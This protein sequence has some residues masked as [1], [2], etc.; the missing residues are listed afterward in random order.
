MT[1][2]KPLRRDNVLARK[3]GD[4]WMLYDADNESI[5]VI[6]GTAEVIWNL[7]DGTHGIDD[8]KKKLLNNF[9]IPRETALDDDIGGIIEEFYELGVLV[10]SKK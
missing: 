2:K 3:M 1:D 4:E 5:H 6:N 7:C 9:A 8:M 10:N